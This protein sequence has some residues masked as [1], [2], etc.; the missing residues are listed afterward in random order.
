MVTFLAFIMIVV[1]EFDFDFDVH[2][3]C[4]FLQGL[5][6][7]MHENRNH[8]VNFLLNFEKYQIVFGFV[9]INFL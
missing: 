3:S 8:D 1:R 7:L 4:A 9:F 5:S 6:F 2:L